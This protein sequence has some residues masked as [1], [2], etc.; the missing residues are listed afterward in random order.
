MEKNR[1]VFNSSNQ[2]IIEIYNYYTRWKL[3]NLNKI[4]FLNDL[5]KVKADAEYKKIKLIKLKISM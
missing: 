1:V 3:K 5:V 2:C 4:I